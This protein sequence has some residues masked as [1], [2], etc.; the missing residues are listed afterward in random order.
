[1]DCGGAKT[2]RGKPQLKMNWPHKNAKDHKKNNLS[3][4]LC[5]LCVLSRQNFAKNEE[6]SDIALR[7]PSAASRNPIFAMKTRRTRSIE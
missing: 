3:S 7:T 6:F 4:Y 5:V 2:Q 1:M